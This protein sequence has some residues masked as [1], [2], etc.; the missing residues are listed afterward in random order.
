MAAQSRCLPSTE[1][2][3]CDQGSYARVEVGDVLICD[4][5]F[6][7]PDAHMAL[8]SLEGTLY[9]VPTVT[10]RSNSGF[11]NTMLSLPQNETQHGGYDDHLVIVPRSEAILDVY[12]ND[13]PVKT[14]LFLMAGISIPKLETID[15]FEGVLQLAE[16][17]DTPGPILFLRS[18]LTSHRIIEQYPLRCYRLATH[19]DWRTEAKLASSHSL[20]LDIFNPIHHDTLDQLSSKALLSLFNLH[21]KRQI[22]FRELLNCPE[23]FVAGNRSVRSCFHPVPLNASTCSLV[24]LTIVNVA[25]SQ[26]SKILHGEF[27]KIR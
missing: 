23:R 18:A 24:R 25:V 27:S 1:N 17:W 12:E 16:K 8:R 7:P 20:T 10:L 5:S 13:F 11:F 4:P 19:F 2:Q 14:L 15:E 21:R 26:N 9:R 3:N 22:M 6:S